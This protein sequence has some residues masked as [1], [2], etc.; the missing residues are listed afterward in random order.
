MG[1]GKGIKAVAGQEAALPACAFSLLQKPALTE[2]LFPSPLSMPCSFSY[3]YSVEPSLY[4][5]FLPFFSFCLPSPPVPGNL[6][7]L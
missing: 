3:T 1:E 7:L 5:T 2:L 6:P 4:W